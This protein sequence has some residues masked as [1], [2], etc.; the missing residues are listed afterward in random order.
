MERYED[1]L[2]EAIAGLKV[3]ERPIPA[4]SHGQVLVKMEAAPCNPS[5][6]LLLQGRYGSLKT[7]SKPVFKK[8]PLVPLDPRQ[9]SRSGRK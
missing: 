6:L 8:A 4:L 2:S 7:L 5:D 1:G 3:A 9:S